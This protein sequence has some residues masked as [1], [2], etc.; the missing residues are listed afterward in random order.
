MLRRETFL[1]QN[2]TL[3]LN[4]SHRVLVETSSRPNTMFS[5]IILL[6]NTDFYYLIS[7]SPLYIFIATTI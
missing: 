3:P 1:L 4:R 5:N 7:I 2:D 6:Q